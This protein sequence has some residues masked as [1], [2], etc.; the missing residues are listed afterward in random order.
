MPRRI[1]KNCVQKKYGVM[2]WPLVEVQTI[3]WDDWGKGGCTSRYL[4]VHLFFKIELRSVCELLFFHLI[5]FHMALSRL[6]WHVSKMDAES[7][8]GCCLSYIVKCGP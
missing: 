6:I 1:L 5:V 4:L 2:L 3:N 7:T 8:V